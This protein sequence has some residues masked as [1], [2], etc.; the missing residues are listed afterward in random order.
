MNEDSAQYA[1]AFLIGVLFSLVYFLSLGIL[2]VLVFRKKKI[3]LGSTLVVSKY[4]LVAFV[5]W[6]MIKVLALKTEPL[7]IGIS[8]GPILLIIGTIVWY[9]YKLDRK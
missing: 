8:S 4:A 6:M 2:Y 3:A 7:I 5:L 1:L 9:F